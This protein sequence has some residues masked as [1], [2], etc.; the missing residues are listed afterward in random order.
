MDFFYNL[1]GMNTS[2]INEVEKIQLESNIKNQTSENVKHEN[3]ENIENENIENENIEN[4]NIENENI[5]N[6]NIKEL[7][8]I[9][10]IEELK[11]GKNNLKKTENNKKHVYSFED[12]IKEIKNKLKKPLSYNTYVIKF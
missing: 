3:I 5:E 10:S 8:F 12:E 7:K 6:D 1:F 2:N 11:I 4:E 9:P